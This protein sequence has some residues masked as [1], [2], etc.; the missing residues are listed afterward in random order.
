MKYTTFLTGNIKKQIL[1][2]AAPL[3]LGNILQQFYGIVD[4]LIIGRFLGTDAFASIGISSAVM[5]LFIFIIQGFCV[6][7]SILFAKLYGTG[8]MNTFRKEFFVSVFTGTLFTLFLSFLSVLFLRP[9]LEILKT[10]APLKNYTYDY[11]II[12]LSCLLFTYLYNLL[13]N[14]LRAIGN[15]KA[16]S[17][18]LFLSVI[19]NILLDYFFILVFPMGIRGAALAT[20]ASQLVSAL[21]CYLYMKQHFPDL[22]FHQ[23]D[24][25]P[26]KKL[27]MDTF[28]FGF[29][30]SLHQSSIYIGKILVQGAVNTLGIAGIAA[31]TASMRIEGILNAFGDSGGQAMSILISQNFGAGKNKRIKKSLKDGMHLHIGA[32]ILLSSCMFFLAKLGIRLFLSPGE[33]RA[34]SYGISYL[35]IISLFYFLNYIGN[36]YVGYFRGIGKLSIPFIGSSLQILIRVL[37][38]F[39]LI[40]RWKLSA[41]AVATGIG[42]VSIVVYQTFTYYIQNADNPCC[43]S[44]FRPKKI[45]ILQKSYK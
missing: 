21:C 40:G 35:R 45:R 18:F 39:L 7:L 42:W 31:Y 23:K 41:L 26:D 5:N 38:T 17:L 2:L 27:I 12:I 10:P 13:A 4:S 6:G 28:A 14:I 34:L 44:S 8:D 37:F 33:T 24:C 3:L 20:A 11:L 9:I 30:S 36:A 1:F 16:A 15:T 32:A 19:L 22:L 29:A 43:A 25:Q